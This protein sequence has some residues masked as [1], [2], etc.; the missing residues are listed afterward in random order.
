M[1]SN[2][3]IGLRLGAGYAILIMLMVAM[4]LLAVNAMSN[5]YRDLDDIVNDNVVKMELAQEMNSSVL[6]VGKSIR[7]LL[8]VDSDSEVDEQRDKIEVARARYNKAFEALGKMPASERGKVLLKAIGDAAQAA[9]TVNNQVIELAAAHKDAEAKAMMLTRARPLVQKW[10]D[11]ILASIAFQEENNKKQF[12]Q[13][14]EDYQ[15]GL[16]LLWILLVAAGVL[17]VGIGWWLTRSITVPLGEAVAAANS[18][19]EGDLSVRIEVDRK[20]E[21]GELKMAMQKMIGKLAEIIGEVRGTADNLSN[22]SGQVSATAQS[23][24][25]SSSQQSDSAEGDGWRLRS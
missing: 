3:R 22:A 4:T 19:S 18:L 15:H 17:A 14:R 13:S 21:T 25:Q 5:V 8:L 6:E 7:T 11:E 20:D 1:L 9:R 24:S 16:R 10:Q 23:L 2:L 12:E